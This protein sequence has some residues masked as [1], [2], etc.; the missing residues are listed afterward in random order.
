MRRPTSPPPT[1]ADGRRASRRRA[2]RRRRGA[3]A[4][5]DPS[6]VA[7][8]RRSLRDRSCAAAGRGRRLRADGCC[9][10]GCRRS[11]GRSASSSSPTSLFLASLRGRWCRSTR[12]ARG[13]RPVVAAVIVQSLA[14]V[15]LLGAR[16][17]SSSTPVRGPRGAAP[18]QLLHPGHGRRRPAR[19]ADSVGGIA[20]A[21]VGTLEQI[22][23]ALAITVPLGLVARGLPQRGPRPLRPLRP[24]HRR[25]DD[26]AAVDRRRPVHLRDVRSSASASSSPGSPPR[27]R[28][29]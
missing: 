12:T 9:S 25:G 8:L 20:H 24:H 13:A 19:P 1:D 4:D 15:L 11:P 21:I 29:P 16:R 3:R 6:G 17:S 22:A 26:R 18:P 10:A 27:W 28:S 23:I 7:R 2:P 5:A 14:V